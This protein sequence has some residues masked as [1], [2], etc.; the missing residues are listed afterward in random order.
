MSKKI[1][2]LGIGRNTVTI[3]DLVLD[4]GYEIGNLLHYNHS[5]VGEE[6]FGVKISGSFEH[7]LTQEDLRGKII[8]LSMGDLYVRKHLFTLLIA[9]G[10]EIPTLIHPSCEIS[11]FCNIGKGVQ[12]LPK[13]IV[14]GDSSIGDNT[15]ITVNTVIAHSSNIGSHCLVSGNVM[16]GAYT[17]IGELTHIGQ[18]STVVSG[19]VQYIG[20]NCIL[21]AGSTLLCNMPDHT[22]FVGNPAR[23]LTK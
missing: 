21:G 8:A 12:I 2:I 16:V 10:A 9:K 17:S 4:C 3:M 18:G 14:Q 11:R 6:Y 20:S 22:I 13:S 5:R 19:K 1:D 7:L 15:I 23:Q